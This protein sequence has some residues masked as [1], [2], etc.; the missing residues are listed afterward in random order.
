MQRTIR[1]GRAAVAETRL[2]VVVEEESG[3]SGARPPAAGGTRTTNGEIA[4][5]PTDGSVASGAVLSGQG[6]SSLMDG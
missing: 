3:L 4:R 5:N 2:D 1:A 6:G